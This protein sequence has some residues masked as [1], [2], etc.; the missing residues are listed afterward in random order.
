MS[1][2]REMAL[3]VSFLYAKKKEGGFYGI[4]SQTEKIL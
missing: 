2:N 4:N 3:A 1:D